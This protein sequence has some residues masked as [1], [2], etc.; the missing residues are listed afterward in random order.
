MK[1]TKAE[2]AAKHLFVCLDYY[3]GT[4]ISQTDFNR[5]V[6]QVNKVLDKAA[7]A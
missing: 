3:I 4:R 7:K 6:G 5:L 1:A 2:R